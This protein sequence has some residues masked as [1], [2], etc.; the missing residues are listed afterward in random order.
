MTMSN[1]HL[2]SIQNGTIDPTKKPSVLRWL[3]SLVR[4]K[5]QNR[6][7]YNSVA[8]ANN[9]QQWNED[10]SIKYELVLDYGLLNACWEDL[11]LIGDQ[12]SIGPGHCCLLAALVFWIIIDWRISGI[13]LVSRP[14]LALPMFCSAPAMTFVHR[15]LSLLVSLQVL[16]GAQLIA[17]A[18]SD[19]ATGG[20]D[21]SPLQGSDIQVQYVQLAPVTDHAAA[22]QV[23]RSCP[24]LKGDGAWRLSEGS[25]PATLA[26]LKRGSSQQF[27]C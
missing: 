22:N 6:H 12:L 21:G 7:N 24:G 15:I 18:S 5:K 26:S 1:R 20:V 2:K 14:L 27:S 19:P 3:F 8:S 4:I 9:V 11:F 16:Q 10:V 25:A 23:R 13:V 17:V